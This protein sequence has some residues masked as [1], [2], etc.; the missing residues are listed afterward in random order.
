MA[1]TYRTCPLCKNKNKISEM[2]EYDRKPNK[3]YHPE[4]LIKEKEL[5]AMRD[6]E[7][8]KKDKFWEKLEGMLNLQYDRIPP[9]FYSMAENLRNG[10]PVFGNKTND[11]RYKDGFGWDIMEATLDDAEK[12]IRYAME[13]KDFASLESALMYLFKILV[14]RIPMTNRKVMRQRKADEMAEKSQKRGVDMEKFQA[15]VE[16]EEK[17]RPRKKKKDDNDISS[18]L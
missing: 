7:A 16:R 6:A 12:N 8:V 10:N 2:V 1:V 11:R 18:F 13:S 3:F 5:Q 9:R 17:P 4:C 15:I 14:N